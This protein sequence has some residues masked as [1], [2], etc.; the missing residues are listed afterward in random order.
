M[1]GLEGKLSNFYLVILKIFFG[2]ISGLFYYPESLKLI[3][4]AEVQRL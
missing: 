4:T 3:Q 2:K 1:S